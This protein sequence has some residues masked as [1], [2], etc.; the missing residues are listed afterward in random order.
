VDKSLVIAET[1]HGAARY[2]LLET[3]RQYGWDRVV[4]SSEAT[5]LR[6]RHRDWYLAVAEEAAPELLGL[7]MGPKSH[8]HL[9]RLEADHDNL[10]GAL[11]WSKTEPNGAETE[12]RLAGALWRLWFERGHWSEGRGWL[13]RSL[14]RA[15]DTQTSALLTALRGA[16]WLAWHQR[17]HE[18]AAALGEKGLA[19]S[20][21]LANNEGIAWSLHIL[22]LI[23]KRNMDYTRATPLFADSLALGREM[24]NK[25]WVSTELIQLGDIARAQGDRDR[26][27]AL[28]ADAL[29]LAREAGESRQIAYS[30]VNFAIQA[31]DQGDYGRAAHIY[32]ESLA[33]LR[34]IR[35]RGFVTLG[36]LEGLA[37]VAY[38]QGCLERAA[39]LFGAAEA[40]RESLHRLR[41]SGEEKYEQSVAFMRAGL[42]ESMFVA[43]W[44]E[45][46]AMTLEQ[47]IEYALANEAN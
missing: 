35:D 6:N 37:S 18:R 27:A 29:A 26:A 9:D 4:E 2:R 30:L 11:E 7:G 22:G 20:R 24:G 46:R 25:W 3:V 38:Q 34:E 14:T 41:I 17:D 45:G 13:E 42:G 40:F 19:L 12:L 47:A 8:A 1:Q 33:L 44:A 31:L 15:G 36:C 32:G 39:T 21:L 16:A 5:D 43:A 23:A 10:R 28:Y